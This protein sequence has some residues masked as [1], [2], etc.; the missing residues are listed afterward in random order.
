MKG[1]KMKK[2]LFFPLTKFFLPAVC[3]AAVPLFAAHPVADNG[4]A[5]MAIVYKKCADPKV[6]AWDHV[7]RRRNTSDFAAKELAEH[8]QKIT[9]AKFQVLEESK[10]NKKQPAFF[11]GE[12]DFAKQNKIDLSTLDR[13]EWL[14]KSVG[15]NFVIAGGYNWGNDI[16]VYKFL[17]NELGCLWL[18]YENTYTPRKKKLTLPEISKRGKP[19]FNTRVL[20]IPPTGQKSV[21]I[22]QQMYLFLRRNRSNFQRDP[23]INSGQFMATHSFYV[24]VNPDI[25]FKTHPEYFSMNPH[26]KRVCGTFKSRSGGQLCLSNPEVRNITEA[27][28]RKF[29]AKDRAGTP[30]INWPTIYRISQC[31]ATDFICCCP[32]CKKISDREGGDSGLLLDFLNDISRRISKDYPEITIA[33]SIYCSTEKAPKYIRPE[34]NISL[35]WCDLY[36]N[37]DCFRPLEHPINA[38]QKK[39]ISDWLKRGIPVDSVWDYWNMGGRWITPPRIETMVDAIAPDLRFLYKCGVRN[40]F[41]E[42][43]HAYYNVDTNFIE[44]QHWLGQQMLDDLSKDENKLIALFMKHH[45]GPAEKPM[46]EALNVIRK[47]VANVKSHMFYTGNVS[48]PFLNPAF[49]A[50]VKKPLDQAVKMTEAGSAY[51]MRVEQEY[52][53]VLRAQI[54]FDNLRLGK[55]KADLVKEYRAMRTRQ[56]EARYKGKE[57]KE[58]LGIMQNELAKLEFDFPTPEKFKHLPADSIRKFSSLDFKGTKAKD[59]SS[60]LKEVVRVGSRDKMRDARRH[61]DPKDTNKYIVGIHNANTKKEEWFNLKP[62]LK[63]DGRYHWYCIRNF[64]FGS[65]TQFFA[66][67]WWAFCDLSSVYV[68]GSDNRWDIWF[69]LRAAGPAYVQGSKEEN[70]FFIESIILT[71]PNAVK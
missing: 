28:L 20:Y 26:G 43:E 38:G 24:F 65:K 25:Y 68:D 10:W 59:P 69:S 37:S 9:G 21:K 57:L 6:Q 61:I 45:Y 5:K 60:S 47:A 71:K 64:Q 34:K 11:I 63:K 66:W 3:C 27:Q 58:V 22:S 15:R 8:L 17:E 7:F 54:F 48:Q 39:I 2:R 49:L 18:S 13:E 62:V 12:T 29:I 23:G 55:K 70:N 33:T 16:A 36:F 51:R 19:T 53:P 35:R 41:T 56:L 4:K 32:E 1:L 42:T 52:L 14:Y 50:S 31:D 67:G 44:L 30:K 46:T 40:Y